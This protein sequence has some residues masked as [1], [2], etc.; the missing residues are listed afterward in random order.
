MGNALFEI[1]KPHPRRG[2]IRAGSRA[3]AKTISQSAA[4][5]YGFGFDR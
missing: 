1:C 3:D 4:K 5:E 2:A